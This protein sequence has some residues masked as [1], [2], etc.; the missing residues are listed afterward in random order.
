MTESP[1][2][3][4][5]IVTLAL[6]AHGARREN[7]ETV[8]RY[9]VDAECQGLPGHGL[10]R[11]PSYCE[12]LDSGKVDGIVRPVVLPSRFSA[13]TA[14]DA[15]GGFAYPAI[16]LLTDQLL[17]RV[18]E[19]GVAMGTVTR[20]HHFGAAGLWVERIARRG[21]L[22][23][24]LGNTPKA[25][26]APGGRDALIGTNPIAFAAPLGKDDPL[27]IDLALSSVPRAR[28]NRARQ[29]GEPIPADWAVD[30]EGQPTTDPEA[31][32]RGALTAIGGP[33]GAALALMVEIL[34]A[35]LAGANFGFQASSFLDG[36]GAAP[37]TGQWMLVMHPEAGAG[38]FEQR[39]RTL[40]RMFEDQPGVRLPGARRCANARRAAREGLDVDPELADKLCHLGDVT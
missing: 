16:E 9:L 14:V 40:T 36:E 28:I 27:I 32:L 25:M 39:M 34:A 2:F 24:L 5:E 10:S 23:L 21:S 15:V 37:H 1:D 19:T 17:E 31:A 20:S 38:H 8:A 13:A 3:W 33:K 30:S 12:Q 26:A 6:M 35:G 7:A 18:N 11:V 4:I 22:A 29:R